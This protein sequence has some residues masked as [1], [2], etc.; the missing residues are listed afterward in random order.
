MKSQPT[1]GQPQ[2]LTTDMCS[3]TWGHER[4]G[5]KLAIGQVTAERKDMKKS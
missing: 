5:G 4:D 1:I 2:T 3:Q